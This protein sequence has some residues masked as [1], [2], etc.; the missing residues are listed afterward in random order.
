M[1]SCQRADGENNSHSLYY[2]V[3]LLRVRV[4]I[5]AV[6]KQYPL[7]I[8]VCVRACARAHGW[9]RAYACRCPEVFLYAYSL[10]YPACNGPPYCHLQPVCLHHVFR[11]YIINGTIL[12]KNDTERKTC[13]F[14]FKF[15]SKHFSV[16]EK[17]QWDIVINVKKSSCKVPVILVQF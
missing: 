5:V 11:H 7:H 4:T 12:E 17:I 13:V 16:Q 3:T 10:N 8:S 2:N 6:E 1:L 9:G 15:Y 14:L